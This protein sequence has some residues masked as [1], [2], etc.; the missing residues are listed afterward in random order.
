MKRI[1]GGITA[2]KGFVASGVSCGIKSGSRDL[3]VI[4]SPEEPCVAAGVFTTNKVKAA[5]VH[6]TRRRLWKGPIAM[7]VVVNSGNANC[8]TGERGVRDALRMTEVCAGEMGIPPDDVLV[9]STGPIGKFLPMEK[10][11]EG[12]RQAVKTLTKELADANGQMER[13]LK[14]LQDIAAFLRLVT[15]AVKLAASIVVLA[16]A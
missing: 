6:I 3:A 2:P 11:E 4:A 16:A 14:A 7:A 8:C 13:D 9:A 12:I 5:P 1:E 15:E 10:V